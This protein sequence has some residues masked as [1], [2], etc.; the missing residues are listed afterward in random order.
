M[1]WRRALPFPAHL[2]PRLIPRLIPRPRR[3]RTAPASG[4]GYLRDLAV[5]ARA[6]RAAAS[7]D[8]PP[9]IFTGEAQHQDH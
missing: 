6:R 4:F 2:V 9:D 1:T 3:S 5:Q 7:F 8:F